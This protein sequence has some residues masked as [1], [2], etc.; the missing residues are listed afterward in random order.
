MRIGEDV[1]TIF[2][3]LKVDMTLL[4]QNSSLKSEWSLKP[5]HDMK[6]D[7][8]SARKDFLSNIV[9]KWKKLSKNEVKAYCIR[10]FKSLSKRNV[11]KKWCPMGV[12]LPHIQKEVIMQTY[13]HEYINPCNLHMVTHYTK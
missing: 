12:K 1:I 4:T 11:I 10:K 3:F 8:K 6:Q 2:K 7:R 5:R 9:Y 13:M